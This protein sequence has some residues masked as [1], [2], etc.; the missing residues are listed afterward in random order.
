MH[1]RQLG[2]LAWM[3]REQQ[4]A[5]E[6]PLVSLCYDTRSRLFNRGAKE[7][8][9]QLA[10]LKQPLHVGI[11]K[12]PVLPVPSHWQHAPGPQA[13]SKQKAGTWPRRGDQSEGLFPVGPSPSRRGGG[14]LES[15]RRAPAR[16]PW[17]TAS[18]SGAL[19]YTRQIQ[20]PR[21]LNPQNPRYVHCQP[22]GDSPLSA[23][24]W[25]LPSDR[26]CQFSS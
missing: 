12:V 16:P 3:P 21:L 4:P 22:V 15:T 5:S 8:E 7:A 24:S 13:A 19:A 20:S 9:S 25:C 2:L 11:V 6:A 18:G 1:R 10:N 14:Q 17:L 23:T 26:N